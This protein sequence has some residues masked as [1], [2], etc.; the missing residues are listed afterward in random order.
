[1]LS[2]R[3]IGAWQK[4]FLPIS[5]NTISQNYESINAGLEITQ[6]AVDTEII[7]DSNSDSDKEIQ[8]LDLDECE[9]IDELDFRELDQIPH[10]TVKLTEG[11]VLEE[12]MLEEEI[13]ISRD[14]PM[15]CRV[16]R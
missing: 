13:E 8:I 12:F 16:A 11:Q 6:E 5:G 14:E 10:I 7:E 4:I 1:M 3:K 9:I 2:V 15:Y